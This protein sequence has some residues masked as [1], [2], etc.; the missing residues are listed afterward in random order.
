MIGSRSEIVKWLMDQA[1][2]TYE[3]CPHKE[4]RSLTANSYYWSLITE[5]SGVMRT[6]KEECHDLML[7]RYGQYLKDKDGNIVCVAVAVGVTGF[8]G[9]YEYVDKFRGLN[10]YKVI[11]G[12][13]LYDSNEF[14]RLLDGLISECKELGIET[15]PP[16]EIKRLRGYAEAHKG[17]RDT[18]ES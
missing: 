2:G 4:K 15:L 13:H 5:L 1:D 11:K 8:D 16:H 10:R 7:R 3:C 17:N 14:S 12:S 9:H 6:S 18:K